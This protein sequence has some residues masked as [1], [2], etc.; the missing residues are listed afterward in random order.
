MNREALREMGLSDE[1]INAIMQQ[2]GQDIENAR[3]AAAEGNATAERARA[4]RLQE[5]LDA[6]LAE[7][8]AAQQEGA[9]AAQLRR[10]LD[11]VTAQLNAANKS[12]GIREI[13]ER[14][15]KPK[16]VAILMRLLDHDKITI[17]PDGTHTGLKEQVDPLK[18]GS[19]YLFADTAADKGGNPDAGS[20]GTA[21][22]MNAFLRS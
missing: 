5:Q 1:Q 2:N 13:L 20:P 21:F 19:G 10:S 17:N 3:N 14:E 4:D 16:D 12:T 8:T 18:T 6:T 15:Y 7:L 22:D 11:A 9:N